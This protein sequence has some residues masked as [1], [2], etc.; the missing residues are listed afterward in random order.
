MSKEGGV[1]GKGFVKGDK[2]I[3]RLGRPKSFDQLRKLAQSIANEVVETKQGEK[4]TVV[5]AIMRTWAQSKDPRLV[6]AFVAYAYGKPPDNVEV[7]GPNGGP[8]ETKD[9]T[10]VVAKLLP[11]TPQD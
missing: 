4:I 2:R 7:S 11:D 5:D 10:D 1:T 3:N 9:I 8:I 6:Q